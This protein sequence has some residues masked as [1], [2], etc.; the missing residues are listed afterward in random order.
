MEGRTMIMFMAPLK[1]KSS[2]ADRERER[3]KEGTR[4]R[5]QGIDQTAEDENSQGGQEAVQNYRDRQDHADEGDEEPQP[6]Q[7]GAAREA[8]V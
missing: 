6:A 4:A 1:A 8:T 2:V 7:E 3:E 5:E